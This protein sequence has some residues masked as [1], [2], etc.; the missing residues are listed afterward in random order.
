[1]S[2]AP[3]LVAS[4]PQRSARALS[5]FASTRG[6]GCSTLALIVALLGAVGAVAIVVTGSADLAWYTHVVAGGVVLVALPLSV[7][8]YRPRT[9]MPWIASWVALLSFTIS[10]TL[11][12]AMIDASAADPLAGVSAGLPD[13]FSYIGYGLLV[14]TGL[15]MLRATGVQR[16]AGAA[17]DGA[18]V[19]IAAALL[20]WTYLISP[21]L[22]A[23]TSH[24][25]LSTLLVM[26]SYPVID[27]VL[28]FLMAR[29]A[30]GMRDRGP[31][32][33]L[34][35]QAFGCLLLGDSAYALVEAGV[36]V[37][38]AVADAFYLLSYTGLG[39]A[40]LHPGSRI[41]TTPQPLRTTSLRRSR[42]VVVA[43]SML[44]PAAI[45]VQYPAVTA[46]DRLIIG[47]GLAAITLLAL[48]RTSTAV[49]GH[50]RDAAAMAHA[51][52]HDALTGLPNRDSLV[53]F[54]TQALARR[55]KERHVAVVYVDL[56]GF[57][58]VNESWGRSTGDELI[59]AVAAR[60]RAAVGSRD[61][62]ARVGADEFAVVC[63]E[64]HTDVVATLLADRVLDV[65][66][67]PFLLR[68]GRAHVTASVGLAH[69]R[70]G[71]D[72]SAEE[73]LRDADSAMHRAKDQG[74][75]RVVTFDRWMLES[76]ADRI[77]LQLALR[78]A[79][80]AGA[81]TVAYQPLVNVHTGQLIGFEALAR[82]DRPG[83]GPVS[84]VEFIPVAEDSG[85][86]VRLGTAVLESAVAQLVRWRAMGRQA[87]PL[88]VSVNVAARQLADPDFADVVAR[89]LRSHRLP[90]AALWLEITESV[91]VDDDAATWETL[92]RL[93][94]LGVTLVVDDFGTGYSSLSYL[95]RFPVGAL[96]ID[97]SFV[98]DLG[99]DDEDADDGAIVVAVV[100]MARALGLWV[101]AE[102]VETAQQRDRVR[103]LGCELAQ[104]WLFGRPVDAEQAHRLVTADVPAP[105]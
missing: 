63:E 62:V 19:M 29:V 34:I 87:E 25:E 44:V 76:S 28:V 79:V 4:R 66:S 70:T 95:R 75:N 45:I 48:W 59:V 46:S 23:T 68:A 100:A 58:L 36:G 60:L 83:V 90:G 8:L 49:N 39:A 93:H 40:A 92:Q 9:A 89:V 20:S 37:P 16:D 65:I 31:A 54:T 69:T 18:M 61:I 26:A 1:M 85:L 52:A 80:A 22:T 72:V 97:R 12:E 78:D 82:W 2:T 24:R 53:R 84:P 104:G 15:L 103:D 11:R 96:K 56:D 71:I 102:G 32:L 14:T 5:A 88:H 33:L 67:D 51:A 21:T 81:I 77:E 27:T 86:I 3:R 7:W 38:L 98:A 10:M 35:V 101:V 42:L 17:A 47:G 41:L 91:I 30:L 94:D 57:K 55:Q 43:L 64:Q 6:L 105:V 13:L 99:S 50:A 73:L 74:R